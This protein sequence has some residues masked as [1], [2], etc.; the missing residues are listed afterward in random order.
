MT[1]ARGKAGPGRPKGSV[2]RTTASV[3]AMLLQVAGDLGGEAAMLDWA[4]EN[5]TEFYKL[6]GRLLPHEVSG[7]DGAAIAVRTGLNVRFV[8][9]TPGG[10]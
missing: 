5:P 1:G 4:R 9:A 3:K 6:L 2:N 8:G 10:E 7:P